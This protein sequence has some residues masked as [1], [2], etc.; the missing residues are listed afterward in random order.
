MKD[1]LILF[2][3]IGLFCFAWLSIFVAGELIGIIVGYI[4]LV[5]L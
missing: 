5:G 4:K 1:G 2:T 3:I